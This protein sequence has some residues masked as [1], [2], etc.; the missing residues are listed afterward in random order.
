MKK[1]KKQIHVENIGAPISFA[2]L[3]S[4]FVHVTINSCVL[5]Y[6]LQDEFHLLFDG[7]HSGRNEAAKGQ[8][9][10]LLDKHI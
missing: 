6:P 2:S 8:A 4:K 5:V 10:P 9:L 7:V 1:K 3:K